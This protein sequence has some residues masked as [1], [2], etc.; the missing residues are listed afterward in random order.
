MEKARRG[1]LPMYGYFELTARCNLDC[2]M[3]YVH[4]SDIAAALAGELSAAEW[5]RI[6]DD[7]IAAGMKHA[8]FTGGECLLRK[9]FEELYL[10]LYNR[11]ICMDVNTN[12]LLLT[13]EKAEL[14]AQHPPRRLQISLYGSND[15]GYERV[16]GHREYARVIRALDLLKARGIRPHIARL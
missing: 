1:H 11:G 16:T 15:D 3:C 9:D 12:G 5:K 10:Y 4:K 8:L 2:R 14:F 7:A 13:E 6:F